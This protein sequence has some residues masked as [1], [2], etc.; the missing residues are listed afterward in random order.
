MIPNSP[1]DAVPTTYSGTTFRSRL[2]ADWARTLDLNHIT[3]EYEPETF[4]LPSGATYIPDFRLPNLG[5][6]IEAKGPNVPRIEKTLEFA[7]TRDDLVLIG[8]ESLRD[9]DLRHLFPKIEVPHV[10]SDNERRN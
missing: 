7:R 10:R 4:T 9:D 8:Y 5:T 3:W 6:W 1:T 2:E